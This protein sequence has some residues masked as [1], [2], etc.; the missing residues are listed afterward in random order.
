MSS[1]SESSQPRDP[2][3]VSRIVGGFFTIWDTREAQEHWSGSLSLLQGEVPDPGIEPGS[4][5]LQVDSLPA[6]PPGKPLKLDQT[7]K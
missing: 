7:L 4:P 2:T 3:Q 1:S 6:E 5:E